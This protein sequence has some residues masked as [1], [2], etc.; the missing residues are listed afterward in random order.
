MEPTLKLEW[1]RDHWPR[2]RPLRRNRGQRGHPAHPAIHRR[3]L[4]LGNIRGWGWGGA[5]K[6]RKAEMVAM[7]VVEV[8]SGASRAR[9]LLQYLPTLSHHKTFHTNF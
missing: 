3:A 6:G 8:T 9:L 7:M 4:K 2:R 1:W 5:G